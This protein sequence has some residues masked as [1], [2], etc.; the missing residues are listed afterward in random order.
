MRGVYALSVVLLA[1]GCSDPCDADAIADE[2]AA[3]AGTVTLP[4]CTVL[5]SLTVP[6]GVTLVGAAPGARIELDAGDGP[7]VLQSGGAPAKL[8]NLRVDRV[9]GS[10]PAIESSGNQS[11]IIEDV[12]VDVAEGSGIELDGLVSA[13]LTRV[14]LVGRSPC[15]GTNVAATHGLRLTDVDDAQLVDVTIRR[16]SVAGAVLIDTTA[17]W[18]GGAANDNMNVGVYAQAGVLTMD[19]VALDRTCAAPARPHGYAAYFDGPVTVDT[20]DLL[21]RDNEGFGLV[22]AGGATRPLASHL[23]LTASGNTKPGVWAQSADALEVSGAL[24]GNG[25]GGVVTLDSA[26]VML[27]DLEVR[28]TRTVRLVLET[29]SVPFGD[30]IQI[31]G[32]TP[33]ASFEDV[34]VEDSGRAGLLIDLDAGALPMNT[35]FTNVVISVPP[36][37]PGMTPLIAAR[38]QNGTAL[39]GWDNGITRMNTDRMQDLNRPDVDPTGVIGPCERPAI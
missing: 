25:S 32:P 8:S 36:P 38:V 13:T 6:A 29:R 20:T 23:G 11:V 39:P 9:G 22:H 15:G 30:G 18:S 12:D 17:N 16:F 2:L 26:S 34:L 1:A 28:D 14:I 35:T 3:G 19:G 37:M 7:V 4:V 5:G 31:F 21:V 24:V 33:G 27:H 10:G